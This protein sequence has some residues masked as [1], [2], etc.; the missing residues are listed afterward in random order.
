MRKIDLKRITANANNRIY[1]PNCLNQFVIQQQISRILDKNKIC[2]HKFKNKVFEI[3][4]H[5]K[6]KKIKLIF[7]EPCL[8]ASEVGFI[9][10][11]IKN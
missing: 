2:G 7:F 10:F 4:S 3:G 9:K 8:N 11:E 5:K 1:V 6:R